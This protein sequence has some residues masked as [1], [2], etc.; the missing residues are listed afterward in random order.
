MIIYAAVDDNMG[1]MF[2]KRRQSKDSVLRNHILEETKNSRLWMNTYTAKQF[3]LPLAE[4]IIADDSFLNK[5]EENDFCFVENVSVAEHRERIDKI[6]LFKWNRVYPADR[7]FD[8]QLSE[9]GWKR[10]SAS[11][12]AGSSHEKITEEIWE[13]EK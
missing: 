6:V 3:E 7:Y 5:A 8:I 9:N 1:M 10:T 12:F 11:D 2:N 4:H 13:K